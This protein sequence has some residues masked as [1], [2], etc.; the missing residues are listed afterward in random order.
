MSEDPD[1]AALMSALVTEHFVLQSVAGST[2]GESGSRAQLYLSALSSGLV[3]IGFASASTTALTVMA[4]SV[5]P[6]VFVLGIFTTARLVDTGIEHISALQRIQKIRAYYGQLH[7]D[8]QQFFVS[9]D[10]AATLGVRYSTK[11]LFFTMASMVITVNSV[12][13]GATAGLLAALTLSI[14]PGV[15]A[16]L[17]AVI[18]AAISVPVSWV[19]TAGEMAKSSVR[20][21]SAGSRNDGSALKKR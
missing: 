9:H 15:A 20:F 2:I 14:T 12:L 17:G 8:A 18:A 19:R 21:T 3:A 10:A 13:G 4:A 1:R 5:L 7:P 11:S 16:L 6:T